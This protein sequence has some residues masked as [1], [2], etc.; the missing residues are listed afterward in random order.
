MTALPPLKSPNRM[1]FLDG[2]Q[3]WLQALNLIT[4]PR[5]RWYVVLPLLCNVF[6][7]IF[8]GYFLFSYVND[9]WL[10]P[11]ISWLPD[12]ADPFTGWIKGLLFG[13]VFTLMLPVIVFAFAI[14]GNLL[15][16]PFNGLLSEE[17]LV[18]YQPGFSGPPLTVSHLSKMMV[19]TLLREFR[20][21]TYYLPRALVLVV[22]SLIPLI[23]LISP[24]LWLVFGAWIAALQFLDYAADNQGYSFEETLASLQQQRVRTLGFG[25]LILMVSLVPILNFLVIPVTVIAATRYWLDRYQP[26]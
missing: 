3:Y 10:V 22:L 16:S 19:R 8:A 20:K 6:T 23:N 18:L 1:P 12:W 25:A 5:L 21:L 13:A 17:V 9:S 11:L 7:L 2:L 24:F 4:H 14:L 15:A 26:A